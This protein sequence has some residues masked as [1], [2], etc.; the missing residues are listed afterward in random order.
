M[1][2]ER[3]IHAHM[4]RNAVS[5]TIPGELSAAIDLDLNQVTEVKNKVIDLESPP[6]IPPK[7]T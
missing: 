7:G 5:I 2:A 3:G 6:P 1:H 4:T